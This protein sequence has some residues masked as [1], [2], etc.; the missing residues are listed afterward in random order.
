MHSII[1]W[2]SIFYIEEGNSS[3]GDS[4]Q[5]VLHFMAV[6]FAELEDFHADFLER[7]QTHVNSFPTSLKV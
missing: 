6:S 1:D 4:R 7:M 2:T 3:M 5:V